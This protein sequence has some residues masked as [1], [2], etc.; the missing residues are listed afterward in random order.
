MRVGFQEEFPQQLVEANQAHLRFVESGKMEQIAELFFVA[1]FRVRASGPDDAHS[2][3]FEHG[4]D[5]V[6]RGFSL[7]SQMHD[8][9]TPDLLD[10][11]R[12]VTRLGQTLSDFQN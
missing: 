8:E 12:G 10:F 9:L 11:S 1:A 5:V 6:G 4:D 7:F 3:F 2:G